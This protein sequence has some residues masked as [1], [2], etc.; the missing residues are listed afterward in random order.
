VDNSIEKFT[1]KEMR[2][3]ESGV[4]WKPQPPNPGS[5][6]PSLLSYSACHLGTAYTQGKT[7]EDMNTKRQIH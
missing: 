7:I 3:G 6:I 5:N 4:K 1:A 2:Q